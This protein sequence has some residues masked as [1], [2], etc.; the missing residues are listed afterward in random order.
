MKKITLI[1]LFL[2]TLNLN[3]QSWTT[4]TLDLLTDYTAKVDVD[5]SGVTLTLTAPHD[6]WFGIGFGGLN[7]SAGADVFRTDGI[8]IVDAQATGRLLPTA[9]AI[10]NWNLI[11]NTV[12]NN[13]RT[14]DA[15][16]ELNTG[17][18]D[19]YVFSTSDSSLSIIYAKGNNSTYGYHGNS[20]RGFMTVSTLGINDLSQL[21]FKIYPNPASDILNIKSQINLSDANVTIFD[22]IGRQVFSSELNNSERL[23]I[24]I[25]EWNN[26]V[27]I[28]QILSNQSTLV[29]R[30]IKN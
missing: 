27:Y 13:I 16:R 12:N 24:N 17:N 5:N 3:A 2:I 21:D 1:T 18:A 8:T 29:K 23:T 30:M 10:N 26:G 22:A 6:I 28:I 19:D 15:T 25:N 20:N 9:D 7:M 14:I 4:Q 11:S